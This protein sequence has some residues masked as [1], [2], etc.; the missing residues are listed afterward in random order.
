MLASSSSF[1]QTVHQ[2][3]FNVLLAG[4]LLGF[5]VGAM[6]LLDSDRMFRINDRLN[7]WVS[8]RKVLRP[9]DEDWDVNSHVYRMHRLIGILVFAGAAYALLILA[10]PYGEQLF[11]KPLN[12][13]L[14]ERG[15][16]SWLAEVL[17]AILLAGNI[18]AVIL[19]VVIAIRPETMR[20]I[21]TWADRR[22][23]TRKAGKPLEQMHYHAD[24]FAREHP[25]F[26]GGLML[27]GSAYVL[28]N[29]GFLAFA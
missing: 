2:A 17:R 11:A 5:L 27:I 28:A 29:L 21:E 12:A 9:M 14:V 19:G 8:T 18:A 4:A 6:M 15:A 23:S 26:V 22:I 7:A 13:L 16:A 20:R 24:R 10:A 25:R 3:I 1:V